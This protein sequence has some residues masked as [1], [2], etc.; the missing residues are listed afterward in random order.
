MPI[1]FDP[2]LRLGQPA[3]MGQGDP[4][5]KED[6]PPHPLDLPSLCSQP[7]YNT[8]ISLFSKI[9]PPPPSWTTN[10]SPSQIQHNYTPCLTRLIST[11]MPWLSESEAE[12]ITSMA[13]TSLALRAG[14]TAAP[15]ML[16]AF[17]VEGHDI[18]L[19]EPS[20]TG[21]SVG[22][23][24]WAA[25]LLLAQRLSSMYMV[26]TSPFLKAS[27]GGR[28][29]GLG[30]GTVTLTDLPGITGNLK[31]NVQRNCSERSEVRELDW[32]DPPS[33]EVIPFGSF[34]IV[35]GSDLFYEAEHS[36][37]V[38]AMV[39][40]YLRRDSESRFIVAYP[41]RALHLK[42]ITDF[43]ERAGKR[44][45]VEAFG[46]EIGVE[47]WGSEVVCRWSIYKWKLKHQ[48]QRH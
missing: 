8:L 18:E 12:T 28:C 40:R 47:D 22:H 6:D 15:D 35:I 20:W 23:K 7:S 26:S 30:E 46:E 2:R 43:E 34:D 29:L 39:E 10:P 24:T 41:L 48:Q 21:D 44:F 11:P 32:R 16:R 13:S 45:D 27:I 4:D 42:E 19:F 36:W 5:G 3:M 31:K 38:I 33:H 14:R 25:S 9:T 1:C 17:D 37:M